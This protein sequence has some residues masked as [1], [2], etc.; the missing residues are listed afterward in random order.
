[1]A[2]NVR[3]RGVERALSDTNIRLPF[4]GSPHCSWDLLPAIPCNRSQEH[5]AVDLVNSLRLDFNKGSDESAEEQET[6]RIGQ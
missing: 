3:R 4:L 6:E 1:V 2:K 5:A